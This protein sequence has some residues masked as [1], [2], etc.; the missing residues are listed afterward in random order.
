MV[1]FCR[2]QPGRVCGEN[3]CENSQM[4]SKLRTLISLYRQFGWKWLLFRA[5]Y[6]LR[7]R[8]GILRWQM[9][10]Y[11]WEEKPLESWIKPQV[12]KDAESHVKWREQNVP[13]FFFQKM[14][15]LPQDVPWNPELA[16]QAAEKI[17]AGGFKYFEHTD[18][19]I[20]FPPDWHLD[21][22]TNVRLDSKKHWSQIPD[23]G[24]C[25]IKYVWEA[26][27]FG[28][29]Y[30]LVRAYAQRADERYAEAFWTLIEDWAKNNPPNT[31]ANWKDGQEAGLRVMAWCFGLHGFSHARGTT[32]QRVAYLTAMIAALAKR[33]IQN[34]DYAI[35]TRGN[36]AITEALGLW[37][38]GLLFPELKD[39]EKYFSL[40]RRL[41]EQ[42]AG[43]QIFTDG[44][45]SM[46]SLNYHRFVLHVY[47]Y[48]IRLAQ[49]NDRRFSE[50]LYRAL[51]A[52]IHFLYQ[53]TELQTGLMP[54]FGSIDGALVLPLNTCDFT[55]YRPVLQLGHYLLHGKRLFEKGPW[56]E[57]LFWLCGGQALDALM[58]DAHSQGNQSFAQGGVYTLRSS[59]SMAVIRCV[60]FQARPSH[61]DQLHVDLWWRGHNIACDAG[62]Y[63]YS[64][65]G[66]WQ[67]ALSRTAVHNTVTVDSVDQ[68]TYFSRFTWINWANGHLLEQNSSRWRGEHDGYRRLTD[69][70]EHKRTVL[71]LDNERWLVVDHLTAKHIHHYR[72]HWLLDD[73]PYTEPPEQNSIL[74][75][76]DSANIQVHTGLLNGDSAF[77]IVRADSNS[78]R[79]WRS[80]YYGHKQ[81]AI[82][83][84]LETD[85]PQACFWTFF[86][87]EN[88]LV[89]LKERK[90]NITAQGWRATVNLSALDS[91]SCLSKEIFENSPI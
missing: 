12:P 4:I 14:D 30:T 90:L 25:D 46:Y 28:C 62:T 35:S 40:G 33:I 10:A 82:S 13:A 38:I 63:L 36:H 50:S 56:D 73:F 11:S 87:F 77:S 60:N 3:K 2:L 59:Q 64:G 42:Q 71:M 88:D 66:I 27:R 26:S 23:F 31:G 58:E 67:N 32:P 69:P 51:D 17:L 49:L 89:E 39:S 29:V 79:G 16:V 6:A 9:P 70:V 44:S 7:I 21:P 91:S 52:S 78:V 24:A 74:L 53:L 8:T 1:R 72:L 55:D 5:G 57:D 76:T 54:Q 86:G 37:M 75:R 85:Q 61:A 80:L 18:Y 47:F 45:Y 81:P 48:A 83:L 19:Q 41:L 65:P 43:H 34:I 84:A 20:G 22:S 15:P 68:M